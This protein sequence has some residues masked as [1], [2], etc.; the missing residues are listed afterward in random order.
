M[1]YNLD[2]IGTNLQKLGNLS[3]AGIKRDKCILNFTLNETDMIHDSR[4]LLC[5]SYDTRTIFMMETLT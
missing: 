5:S 2:E 1:V 3:D 4:M